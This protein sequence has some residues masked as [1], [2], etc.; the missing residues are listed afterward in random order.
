MGTKARRADAPS[1]DQPRRV[2]L[3][4]IAPGQDRTFR[5]L[6]SE[7]LGC[8]TH[9]INPN[10]KVCMG[11]ACPAN[12]HRKPTAWQGFIF[13][14]EADR[15]NNLWIPCVLGITE[16]AELDMRGTY[17]RGQQWAFTRDV[18]PDGKQSPVQAWLV[19]AA[20]PAEL[21]EEYDPVAV[22]IHV[23]G[24]HGIKL[25]MPNPLPPRLYLMPSK[26]AKTAAV[27][28]APA[29]ELPPVPYV[30]LTDRFKDHVRRNGTAKVGK[31]GRAI[32][33]QGQRSAF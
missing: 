33:R 7:V 30:P 19:E 25:D 21:R 5:V 28:P 27:E 4:R 29:V 10:T 6:S 22:L 24:Q 12:W 26:P 31:N 14:E 15:V 9:Y 20:I 8:L 23:F 13:A 11:D 2:R 1:A 3:E 17:K 18:P 16:H 32:L